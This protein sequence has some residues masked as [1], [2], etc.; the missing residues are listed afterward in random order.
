MSNETAQ[1]VMLTSILNSLAIVAI[2]I[3]VTIHAWDHRR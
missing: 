1:L 3:A 2:G